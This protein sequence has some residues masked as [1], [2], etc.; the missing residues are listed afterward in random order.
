MYL[1]KRKFSAA[2]V[3]VRLWSKSKMA[4][5]TDIISEG[6]GPYIDGKKLGP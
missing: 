5:Y 3:E 6:L 1:R 4:T 2:L